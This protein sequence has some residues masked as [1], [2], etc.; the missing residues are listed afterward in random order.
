[1]NWLVAVALLDWDGVFGATVK[2]FGPVWKILIAYWLA[3]FVVSR[4]KMLLEY[5]RLYNLDDPAK[6][7]KRDYKF[8]RDFESKRYWWA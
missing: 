1:M 5:R 2:A 4:A 7:R 3:V 8:V 6:W